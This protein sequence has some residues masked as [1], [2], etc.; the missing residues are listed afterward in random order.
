MA[1]KSFRGGL[2]SLLE[3]TSEE[4]VTS[5]S[6]KVAQKLLDGLDEI[7]QPARG[8]PRRKDGT[9]PGET[10]ATFIMKEDILEKLKALAYWE[11]LQIKDLVEEMVVSYI[12]AKDN[13]YMKKVLTEYRKRQKR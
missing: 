11:R 6:T 4:E 1:K 10:R 13:S 7:E 2:D 8:L 5:T 3:S 12:D 9:L